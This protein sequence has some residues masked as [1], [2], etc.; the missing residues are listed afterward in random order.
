MA[1]PVSRTSE[2]LEPGDSNDLLASVRSGCATVAASAR[3]VTL[4]T[5]RSVSYAGELVAVPEIRPRIDPATHY[6]GHGDDTVAFFVTLDTINFGSGYFPLLRKRPGM[7]GYF[8]IASALADRFRNR[9]PWS[10]SDLARLDAGECADILGQ[11][12]APPAIHDLMTLFARALRDL[13]TL[14]ESGYGGRFTSL[15]AAAD[16][17]ANR[18]VHVLSQMPLF[19]DVSAYGTRQVPFFKRAQLMAADLALALDGQGYGAFTDLDRLTIFADNLVPHVLWVD[20]V[21]RYEEALVRRIGS[22]E[23]IPAGT[24]AEVEIRACAVHAVELLVQE[25][26]RLGRPTTAQTL[27]YLLWTRGQA[28]AYKAL[29]R[30]RTRTTAY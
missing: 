25:M 13:G 27:D 8:T 12:N 19:R 16:H 7:S 28:P 14:L 3:W 23:L 1:L 18:L 9:G 15:V 10:A 21:L 2:H 5:E 6:L 29:P 22:G 30:H 4:C 20:G 24:P 17:S 11:Q 26:A